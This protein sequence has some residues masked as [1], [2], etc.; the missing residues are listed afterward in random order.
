MADASCVAYE[1]VAYHSICETHRADSGVTTADGNQY[2][3][4]VYKIFVA[5]GPVDARVWATVQGPRA[6]RASLTLG[7]V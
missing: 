5:C 3:V 6:A 7:R 2:G 1:W 4:C